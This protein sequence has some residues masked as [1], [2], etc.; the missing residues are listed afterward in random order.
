VTRRLVA[1]VLAA[2]V[3]YYCASSRLEEQRVTVVK[4]YTRMER[5]GSTSHWAR[6]E[7]WDTPNHFTSNEVYLSEGSYMRLRGHKEACLYGEKLEVCE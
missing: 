2:S 6:I 1:L 5:D 7:Y 3:G 4:T